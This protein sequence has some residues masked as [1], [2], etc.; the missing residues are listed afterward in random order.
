M[1]KMQTY[2]QLIAGGWEHL[3]DFHRLENAERTLRDLRGKSD[4][5][6]YMIGEVRD[7]NLDCALYRREG[8]LSSPLW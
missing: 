2:L 7:P 8:R 6:E 1:I 5:Y 4:Q 3:M